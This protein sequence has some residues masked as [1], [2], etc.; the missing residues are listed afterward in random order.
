MMGFRRRYA[1]LVMAL[2]VAACT[3]TP[4][5]QP[6]PPPAPAEAAVVAPIAAPPPPPPVP[7]TVPRSFVVFFDA[8]KSALSAD[9]RRI[10]AD[11]AAAYR[12]HNAHRMSISGHT[13]RAGGDG[14]N[15]KVSLQR[16]LAVQRAFVAA[17]IPASEIGI[18][19][20][21]ESEPAFLTPDQT[22]EPQNRRVEIR[23]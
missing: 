20:R 15:R 16:A 9:A 2:A 11:A 8:G 3:A 19:A 23:F 5:P 1:A 6:A 13:D 4:E 12:T 10:I 21:G 7:A 22:K 17:G 18:A 14:A